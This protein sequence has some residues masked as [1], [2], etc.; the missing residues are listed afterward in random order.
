VAL[1]RSPQSDRVSSSI[2]QNH[3]ILSFSLRDKLR[4]RLNKFKQW[5]L[6]VEAQGYKV[7]APE[8]FKLVTFYYYKSIK[9]W[10]MGQAYSTM[11]ETLKE[12]LINTI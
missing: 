2:G 10:E 3:Q 7:K 6:Q 9:I 4:R 1:G 12:K 8:I 11:I 5:Y